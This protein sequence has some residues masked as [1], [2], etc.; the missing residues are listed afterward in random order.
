MWQ[1]G[2]YEESTICWCL[3]QVVKK[4]ISETYILYMIFNVVL[5]YV[6]MYYLIHIDLEYEDMCI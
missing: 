3:I 1:C 2:I 5:H 6:Y 4:R